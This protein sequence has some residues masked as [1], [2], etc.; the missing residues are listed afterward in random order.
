MTTELKENLK[1]IILLRNI[2]ND[3]ENERLEISYS[4]N[5]NIAQMLA[6]VQLHIKM[7]KSKISD[8]GKIYI[9][10]AETIL[11]EAI[12]E[13]KTLASSISP[14][15]LKNIG[16]V[17]L[18]HDLVLLIENHHEIEC[19][20]IINDNAIKAISINTQNIF[21]QILQLQTINILKCKSIENVSITLKENNGKLFMQIKDDGIRPNI[22]VEKESEAFI[23]LKERVEAFDGKFCESHENGY[24]LE[25]TL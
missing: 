7:A 1:Q 18:L 13:V 4:L 22:L 9:E 5:E 20:V 14:F 10:E 21:Y 11:K 23:N 24:S 25:V 3:D 12:M 6:A 15:T 8:E 19:N 16:F 2:I 17:N